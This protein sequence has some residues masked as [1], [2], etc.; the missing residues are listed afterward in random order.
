MHEQR[1]GVDAA[2][3]DGSAGQRRAPPARTAVS[4]RI[5]PG[6]SSVAARS[7]RCPGSR[8]ASAA[9]RARAAGP[10]AGAI[11]AVSSESRP[12]SAMNH[13]A[14]AATTG[15]SG[16]SGSKI[17]SEPRSS[18]ERC[19]TAASSESSVLILGPP[20]RHSRT[21]RAAPPGAEPVRRSRRDAPVTDGNACSRTLQAPCGSTSICQRAPSDPTALPVV[22]H[23][24]LPDA[25]AT[26]P[27][28][29]QPSRCTDRSRRGLV[30]RA[31]P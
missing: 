30:R 7:T 17:R 10:A 13:G 15:R 8:P 21:R 1:R 18:T 16:C 29:H 20:R 9:C 31:R 3:V 14:P 6:C 26:V 22:P 23:V 5:R 4:C 27:A 24:E 12:N 25:T 19:S 11:Q 2:V 28:E